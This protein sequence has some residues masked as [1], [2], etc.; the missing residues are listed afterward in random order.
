MSSDLCD[1]ACVTDAQQVA[2]NVRT[3]L[4]RDMSGRHDPRRIAL[5]IDQLAGRGHARLSDVEQFGVTD[6]AAFAS[7]VADV[8]TTDPGLLNVELPDHFLGDY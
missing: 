4:T 6:A 3:W 1:I 8:R 5:V 2:R 7:Q